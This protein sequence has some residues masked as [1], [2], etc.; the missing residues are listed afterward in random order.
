LLRILLVLAFIPASL[1]RFD[2]HGW[3]LWVRWLW[4]YK[5]GDSPPEG[6]KLEAAGKK[7]EAA[8]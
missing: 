4:T 7:K 1:V 2:P 8:L 6:E 5:K 3:A